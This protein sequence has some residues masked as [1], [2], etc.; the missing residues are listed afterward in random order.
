MFRLGHVKVAQILLDNGANTT[1]EDQYADTSL[2]WAAYFSKNFELKL[3]FMTFMSKN[4]FQH[5]IL[6]FYSDHAEVLQ[7]L[8]DN[9]ADINYG[10]IDNDTP[11]HL[12]SRKGK[13]T[14]LSLKLCGKL[15]LIAVNLLKKGF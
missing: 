6:I 2:H 5:C 3:L 13:A 1:E 14:F 11:I 9:G 12:A 8:L 15:D 10:D 7:L 4:E